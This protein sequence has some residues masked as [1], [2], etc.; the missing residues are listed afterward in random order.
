MDTHLDCQT[1]MLRMIGRL[2]KKSKSQKYKNTEIQQKTTKQKDKKEIIG[3]FVMDTQLVC[4][5]VMLGMI[6][7]PG[8][9]SG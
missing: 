3:N 2:G 9:L 7:H 8:C 5:T 4:Q 6:E 1:V